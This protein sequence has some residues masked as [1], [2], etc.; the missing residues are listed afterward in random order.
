MKNKTNITQQRSKKFDYSKRIRRLFAYMHKTPNIC[1]IHTIYRHIFKYIHT[2]H[3]Y[4][5]PI[6]ITKKKKTIAKANIATITFNVVYQVSTKL[7]Q[8]FPFS[9]KTFS[10]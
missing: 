8:D 4:N 9:R 6:N 10:I 3:V 1:T 7:S 2:I 5:Q